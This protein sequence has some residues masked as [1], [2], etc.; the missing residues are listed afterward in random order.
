M[1]RLPIL[2]SR[3]L[4]SKSQIANQ[5]LKTQ[6]SELTFCLASRAYKLIGSWAHRLMGSFHKPISL[7]AYQPISLLIVLCLALGAVA[8]EVTV[9][10]NDGSQITGSL[11]EY[12]DGILKIK[13]QKDSLRIPAEDLVLIDFVSNR[14]QVSG[15]AYIHLA[16]G[17]QLLELNMDNEALEEFKAAIRESPRYADAYYELG[18]FW[19]KQGQMNEALEYFSIAIDLGLERPGMAKDFMDVADGYFSKGELEDAAEMYYLLFLKF[20]E[21]QAAEYAAYRAG[22]LFA[23]ELKNNEKALAALEGAIAKFPTSQYADRGLYEVGRIYEEERLPEAAESA[24]LQLISDF[25]SSE[26]NDDAH[27][28]LAR[29]YHQERRNE[30]AIE[31]LAKVM[32]ESADAILIGEAQ[33]ML[34]E[35]IWIVYG[36][37]D[38]LPSDDIHALAWDGNYIWVGTSAG[39]ARFDLETNSFTGDVILKGTDVRTLAADDSDLWVGTLDSGI[40][41]YGKMEETWTTYTKNDGLSSDRALAISIDPN[42]VWVGTALGGV[43][44]YGKYDD[45]WTHYTMG[46]GLTSDNIVSIASTSNGIWCGTLKK[47]ASVFDS[48]TGKWQSITDP[49]MSGEKSVTS[50]AAGANYVWF[51]WYEDLRNGFSRYDALTKSWEEWPFTELEERA[52]AAQGASIDMINLG[53]DDKEAWV[54]T[55][56][57][58]LFYDHATSSWS[59][60]FKCPSGLADH[61]PV[62]VLVEDNSVWFATSYG[63]GR[64]NRNLV[65]RIEQIKQEHQ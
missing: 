55:G 7:L 3:F 17:K 10:M 23:E 9:L 40:K 61:V 60:P 56:R 36:V 58:V 15:K 6:N 38:G 46:D 19:E 37:S 13:V 34:D 47:G 48:L 12:K 14:T 42:N 21:D 22:F 64:L 24:L 28:I 18:K 43:Y 65:D 5:K 63:L 32:K 44:K 29:A 53:A 35:C 62:C 1:I 16:N 45:S 41:R 27:Y 49:S 50:I 59:R 20:P 2:D 31:E 57:E 39:I 25:P 4:I 26:W 54:G 30:D 51:A 11:L 33:Q 52:P 8:Q